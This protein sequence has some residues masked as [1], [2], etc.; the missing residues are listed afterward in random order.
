MTKPIRPEEVAGS[1]SIPAVVIYA[2]NR[3]ITENYRNG[4]ASILQ[5]DVVDILVVE[6]LDRAEIFKRGWLD[7]EEVLRQL[8][9]APQDE[10][11]LIE[12]WNKAD[13]LDR[14]ARERLDFVGH[15]RAIGPRDRMPATYGPLLKDPATPPQPKRP[16]P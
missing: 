5:K 8:G 15:W 2:F 3:L 9:I 11:R 7:V 12:V 13:L 10:A 6:G 16:K 4:R 14:A 1:K